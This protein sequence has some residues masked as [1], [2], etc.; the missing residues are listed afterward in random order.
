MSIF[1]SKRILVIEDSPEIRLVL[2]ATLEGA[3][4]HV[5]ET[6]YLESALI[7]LES[8]K[9]DLILTDLTLPSKSGFDLLIARRASAVLER[10][11]TIVI[12][13]SKDLA[14]VTQAIALGANG[15]ILKP[16]T[17]AIL[18]DKLGAFF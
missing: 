11:P 6:E 2:K 15:Y 3:G 5:V 14:T 7:L 1:A 13:I 10:T 18:L 9:F 8:Q 4:A 17:P 12:S 16:F